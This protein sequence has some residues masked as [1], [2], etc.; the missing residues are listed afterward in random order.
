[1]TD[2]GLNCGFFFS[3]TE[4]CLRN[5]RQFVRFLT[6]NVPKTQSQLHHENVRMIPV[7]YCAEQGRR[8]VYY[9]DYKIIHSFYLL[10][11][12]FFI[13]TRLFNVSLAQISSC[14]RKISVIRKSETKPKNFEE[15]QKHISNS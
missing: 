8:V 6:E 5:S 3:G 13:K 9:K 4:V 12:F 11:N 1:M 2:V 14:W 7:K 10:P 15:K